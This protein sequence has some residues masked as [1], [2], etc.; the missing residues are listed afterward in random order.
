VV[1]IPSERGDPARVDTRRFDSAVVGVEARYCALAADDPL[2]RRRQLRLTDLSERVL[3]I[4][5]RTGTTTL[6]LWP[7][8]GRPEVEEIH[9]VDDWLAVIASGRCVG[10]TAESTLTQYRRHGVVFRRLRGVPPVPVRLVWWRD[11]P[12]PAAPDLVGLLADLY[13]GGPAR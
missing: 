8:D 1:R 9:D 7:P 12:H 5:R 3:A 10:V 4:D 11:D 13:A 6:D 2:A